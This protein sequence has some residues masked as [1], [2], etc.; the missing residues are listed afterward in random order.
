MP[1]S[2][3]FPGPKRQRGGTGNVSHTEH[4][5]DLASPLAAQVAGRPVGLCAQPLH[6][7]AY[8]FLCRL[9]HLGP[10]GLSAHDC[11]DRGDAYAR[12]REQL[13][14]SYLTERRC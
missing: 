6:D 8:P 10:L 14:S 7:A 9:A 11:R 12:D 2:Y 4:E 5:A 13:P 3:S 1:V